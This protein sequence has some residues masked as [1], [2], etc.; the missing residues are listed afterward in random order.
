MFSFISIIVALLAPNTNIHQNINSST[1]NLH[2][3]E[4]IEEE[5]NEF[6]IQKIQ[7]YEEIISN[8]ETYTIR[9]IKEKQNYPRKWIALDEFVELGNYP[10]NQN[11]FNTLTSDEK[12][13]I[14]NGLLYQN[15]V[16]D[17]LASKV[18]RAIKKDEEDKRPQRINQFQQYINEHLKD[19]HELQNES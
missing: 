4:F 2:K 6:D 16:P 8:S 11:T 9:S 5:N 10:W 17:Y 14:Y 15:I 19:I 3:I 18:S 12:I 1:A 7:Y 13:N